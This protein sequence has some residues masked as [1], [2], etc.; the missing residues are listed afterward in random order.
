MGVM[1][2]WSLQRCGVSLMIYDRGAVL[3]INLV[4]VENMLAGASL[5]H[6]A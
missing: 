4:V 5:S 6:G 1:G 3:W 2:D